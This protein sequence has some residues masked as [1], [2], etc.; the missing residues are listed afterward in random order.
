MID[1]PEHLPDEGHLPGMPGDEHK[2]EGFPAGAPAPQKHRAVMLL[3]VL[4]P[5]FVIVLGGGGVAVYLLNRASPPVVRAQPTRP[6]TAAATA[7]ATATTPALGPATPP[8]VPGTPIT[9]AD[10]LQYIDIVQ[11]T[12]QMVQAGETLVAQYTGWLAST[13]KKFDSS[14]DDGMPIHFTFGVGEVI[15]GWDEG[16]AGMRVGGKRRLIIPPALAYGAQGNPQG[17]IPPN[18]TLIFDVELIG[19]QG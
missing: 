3:A 13:R 10:G 5:L 16:I 2:S 17:R 1:R 12:G 8:A 18:A 15:K 6:P 14:Y 11:G 19:I 4:I 9:T 7:A